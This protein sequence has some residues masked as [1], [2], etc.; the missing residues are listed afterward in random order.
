MGYITPFP[1]VCISIK[2][3]PS[4]V[5]PKIPSNTPK[6]LPLCFLFTN[7]FIFK[8]N[9][10]YSFFTASP[11]KPD[12]RVFFCI[13]SLAARAAINRLVIQLSKAQLDYSFA[14]AALL[15]HTSWPSL[16]NFHFIIRNLI[17]F[18]LLLPRQKTLQLLQLYQDIHQR[19]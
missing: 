11:N 16:Q 12:L 8:H 2:K 17:Y 6:E 5:A 15:L 3:F 7:T 10:I 4:K 13:P 9:Q 19:I 18:L 1:V 14:L